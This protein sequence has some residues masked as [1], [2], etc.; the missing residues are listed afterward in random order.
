MRW[1][2]LALNLHWSWNHGADQL[3]ER[4]DAELWEATQN[5]W[6]VLRTVSRDKI[7]ALLAEPEFRQRVDALLRQNRESHNSEAWFQ[8][9]HSNTTLSSVAYFS[10]EFMLS[11]ALPIYSGGLVRV[12]RDIEDF[13]HHNRFGRRDIL[14]KPFESEDLLAAQAG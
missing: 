10:M 4:L 9:K 3:W 12:R 11:E 13:V 14:W 2:E 7:K 8:K 5:P 6:V 1:S